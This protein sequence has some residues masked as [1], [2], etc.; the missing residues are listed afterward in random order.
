MSRRRSSRLTQETSGGGEENTDISNV[1]A[2]RARS[3]LSKQSDET[4]LD[5]EFVNPLESFVDGDVIDETPKKKQKKKKKSKK[6]KKT[7]KSKG[8]KKKKKDDDDDEW[9]IYDELKSKRSLSSLVDRWVALYQGGDFELATHKLVNFVLRCAGVENNDDAE[10]GVPFET[11]AEGKDSIKR[12]LSDLITATQDD[13]ALEKQAQAPTQLI[14]NGRT[15]AMSKRKYVE[16]WSRLV[17]DSAAAEIV[18]DEYFLDTFV[19]WL[20]LMS[21][22]PLTSYRYA[23]TLAALELQNALI[24]VL[25]GAERELGVTESQLKG[26]SASSSSA[27]KLA[28]ELRARQRALHDNV[29]IVE[30]ELQAILDGI[31]VE[32][33]RDVYVEIRAA[34]VEALG[35]WCCAH[36]KLFLDNS[37]TR[38]IA[39]MLSDRDA[40]VRKSA[41]QTLQLIFA[42]RQ[43]RVPMAAFVRQFADRLVQMVR[44]K[45]MRVGIEAIAVVSQLA[46]FGALQQHHIGQVY[47][48]VLDASAHVRAEA[49]RFVQTHYFGR[50]ICQQI[51]RH[52]QLRAARRVNVDE[53]LLRGLLRFM[54]EHIGGGDQGELPA[55][56]IDALWLDM[57][58]S[59]ASALHEDDIGDDDDDDDSVVRALDDNDDNGGDSNERASVRNVALLSADDVSIG[60]ALKNWKAMCDL[61]LRDDD[62]RPLSEIEQQLLAKTLLLSLQKASGASVCAKTKS[63]LERPIRPKVRVG[64]P[65]P[66]I[67]EQMRIDAWQAATDHLIQVLPELIARFQADNAMLALLLDM[68]LS[69]DL[70]IYTQRRLDERILDN[71]LTTLRDTFAKHP[72][73]SVLR[74][75]AATFDRLLGHEHT[76][77]K[78]EVALEQLFDDMREQFYAHLAALQDRLLSGRVGGNDDDDD[79]DGDDDDDDVS[80]ASFV[81]V[82]MRVD[83]LF[84]FFSLNSWGQTSG[85]HDRLMLVEAEQFEQLQSV[86]RAYLDTKTRAIVGGAL[87]TRALHCLAKQLAWKVQSLDASDADETQLSVVARR[88]DEFLLDMAKLLDDYESDATARRAACLWTCDLALPFSRKF[89]GTT[90][91]ELALRN[92]PEPLA[93]ALISHVERHCAEAAR[94]GDVVEHE[95]LIAALARPVAFEA[96][97]K[98]LGAAVLALYPTGVRSS[99]ETIRLMLSKVRKHDASTEHE[100]VVP[101]LRMITDAAYR[102]GAAIDDSDED[103]DESRAKRVQ[104]LREQCRKIVATY[105][106]VRRSSDLYRSYVLVVLELAQSA[107]EATP[108][109]LRYLDC[110]TLMLTKLTKPVAEHCASYVDG[111]L[112]Q[113]A[114]EPDASNDDHAL[115]FS[116]RRAL[117]KVRGVAPTTTASAQSTPAPLLSSS[118]ARGGSS[119]APSRRRSRATPTRARAQLEFEQRS[120]RRSARLAIKPGADFDETSDRDSD[121]VPGEDD[122]DSDSDSSSSDDDDDDDPDARVSPKRARQSNSDDDERASKRQRSPSK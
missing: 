69:F 121:D 26:I 87:A 72:R 94:A 100:L 119:N 48:L 17:K 83:H 86:L 10:F 116:F 43:N 31:F 88:R 50:E 74:P 98:P 111:R 56:V 71:F 2:K 49:V 1:R 16:F 64:E 42:D 35:G 108:A 80:T 107:L 28:K 19:E 21:S 76:R 61:L 112:E 63:E 106:N 110:A 7:K 6:Q 11:F 51:R 103:E 68:P 113:S 109:S 24:V 95:L 66:S 59:H 120:K 5:A 97:P 40:S 77:I 54:V 33:Y 70:S 38:Y 25:K 34:C 114:F 29:L 62:A 44:D 91:T 82:M 15:A 47:K 65:L 20:A 81:N 39:W 55:Y 85:A 79:D 9:H 118:P 75:C 67:G 41:L 53:E 99:D 60:D 78:T 13:E 22:S 57:K 105:G 37:Y 58:K 36:P 12:A 52:Q 46:E 92:V 45:D 84:S 73:D 102:A 30:E 32:R 18:Y 27:E 117:D 115:Y 101:A 122:R 93:A 90:L 23:A 8:T 104:R 4:Q 3:S 89:E 96:L 14:G